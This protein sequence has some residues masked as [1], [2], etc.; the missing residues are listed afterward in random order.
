MR[1]DKSV[2]EDIDL[3]GYFQ[4]IG[5]AGS[6][7]PTLA[8]LGALTAAHAQ[9]IPFENLD[10][11]LRRPVRLEDPA[12]YCKL[13]RDRRGGYCFEQNGLLLAVLCRLGFAAR[14]LGAR[15]RLAVPDRTITPGRTHMLIEVRIGDADWLTDVGV[16]AASLTAPLR[17]VAD[18]EQVTPHDVRRL[19]RDGQRWFHQVRRAGAWVDVYEFTTADMPLADRRIANWYTSTSPET[20][21]YAQLVVAL[22]KPHGVR[23]TLNNN[24]L[25]VRARDG[26]ATERELRHH[27]EL[28]DVLRGEFGIVL[29]ADARFT[30]PGIAPEA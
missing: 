14:P 11:L 26:S 30:V 23:A 20:H 17:L 21:F 10:V 4:R 2:G 7:Q 18:R 29:A 15:V 16:G 12:L 9:S 8:V 22:A 19:Q 1:K 3:D 5:Y 6:R 27:A 13:V 28:L 25:T 24:V